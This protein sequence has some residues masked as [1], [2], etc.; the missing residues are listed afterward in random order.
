MKKKKIKTKISFLLTIML[1]CFLGQ[2]KVLAKTSVYYTKKATYLT[3]KAT[4]NYKNKKNIITFIPKN[5]QVILVKKINKTYYK[6]NYKTKIGYV[7]TNS[8]SQLIKN[9]ANKEKVSS[10]IND[11]PSLNQ[12]KGNTVL[13]TYHE[14]KMKSDNNSPWQFYRLLNDFIKDIS[15]IKNSGINVVNYRDVIEKLKKGEKLYGPH[16]IIQFDD[17]YIS[18]YLYAFPILRDN[19]MKA[20]FFVTSNYANNPG[21]RFA[22]WGQIKEINDYINTDG[23][24]LFEI[25]AHGQT[26]ISLEKKQ[27]ES[28]EE[29]IVRLKNEFEVPKKEIES[30]LGQTTNIFAL[31]FGAG[32]GQAEIKQIASET[33]YEV[34]RGWKKDDDN[35]INY[36]TDFIKFFPVYNNSNI[37]QA[38]DIALGKN[39]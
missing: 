26:H 34:V 21:N 22:S 30:N 13:L 9:N 6:V 31:P 24:K 16:I 25:G 17:G 27:E 20:T 8:I 33:G 1:F 23:I 38:I 18:D 15:L 29:W 35:F 39:K 3:K 36:K 4:T 7:S 5:E 19:N 28:N 32:F 11:K 10:I 14:I 2:V 37:Q 12:E